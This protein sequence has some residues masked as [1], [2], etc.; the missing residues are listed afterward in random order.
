MTTARSSTG[1]PLPRAGLWTPCLPVPPTDSRLAAQPLPRDGPKRSRG[2]PE[3]TVLTAACVQ[4]RRRPAG[5]AGG[6][7]SVTHWFKQFMWD[8]PEPTAHRRMCWG[9]ATARPVSKGRDSWALWGCPG[10]GPRGPE[11]Q[12]EQVYCFLMRQL[13]KN[14]K[15][16]ACHPGRG[17]SK[18][19]SPNPCWLLWFS[20]GSRGLC[21]VAQ[22]QTVEEPPASIFDLPGVQIS[23]GGGLSLVAICVI[24]DMGPGMSSSPPS[25]R[26][27]LRG[28]ESSGGLS[29]LPHLGSRHTSTAGKLACLLP[30][31]LTK[32]SP[33]LTTGQRSHN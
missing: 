32:Q 17:S 4:P 24:S 21:I 14:L 5:G 18:V 29:V 27:L 26:Q 8:F 1:F 23:L 31:V 7:Q 33:K 20:P 3:P 19:P 22:E 2:A 9:R 15:L 25:R 12:A 16:F 6:R 30:C 11:T 28:P 13:G 10:D